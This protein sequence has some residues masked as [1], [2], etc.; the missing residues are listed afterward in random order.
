[1]HW[2]IQGEMNHFCFESPVDQK[3]NLFFNSCTA[4]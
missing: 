1:L 3:L 4:H 2:E